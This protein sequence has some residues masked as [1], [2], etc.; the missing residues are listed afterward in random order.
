MLYDAC[1]ML[2][3]TCYLLCVFDPKFAPKRGQK[4][5]FLSSQIGPFSVPKGGSKTESLRSKKV[6]LAAA[7]S[8]K[9]KS[10]R[11]GARGGGEPSLPQT[12]SLFLRRNNIRTQRP[13][14]EEALPVIR[15]GPP[16]SNCAPLP[17]PDPLPFHSSNR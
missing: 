4:S 16:R 17:P 2:Y 12:P 11:V 1:Y 15:Q 8:K 13:S 3:D 10:A 9:D 6:L 7:R 5:S 14:P